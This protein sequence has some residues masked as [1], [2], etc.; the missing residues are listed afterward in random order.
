MEHIRLF[1]TDFE[2][3]GL[4]RND[5]SLGSSGP[6]AGVVGGQRRNSYSVDHQSL[7]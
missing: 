2:L 5:N 7:Q 1:Q 6:E 4:N 3:Q